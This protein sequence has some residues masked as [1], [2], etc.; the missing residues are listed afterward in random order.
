MVLV[1]CTM[2]RPGDVHW[3]YHEAGRFFA[4]QWQR[5]SDGG[6]NAED[7]PLPDDLRTALRPLP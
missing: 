7:S 3:L 2:T 5:Y 1:S 4:A 6:G